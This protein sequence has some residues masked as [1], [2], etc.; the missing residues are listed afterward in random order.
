LI[1]GQAPQGKM[2]FWGAPISALIYAP[3]GLF[4]PGVALIVFKLTG[5]IAC[6]IGL[7]LLFREYRPTAERNGAS[8][9]WFLV[10]FTGLVMLYQPFW[11]VY[12]VGGQTTP[13]VFLLLVLG[14][15][16][17]LRQRLV[18]VAFAMLLVVLMKPA[19]AFVPAILFLLSG[20]RFGVA[21]VTLFAITGLVSLALFGVELHREFLDILRRGSG[22]PS[23]WPF[24]SSLYII[25][26]AFR[27][28]A[29]Q[30]PVPRAGGWFP[31]ALR[32]ALKLTVLATFVRLLVRSRKEPWTILQRRLFY[33][34]GAIA[35]CLLISQVVWEHYLA[36]LF[37]P[38]V[39]LVAGFP[40][41][42]R[43]A[44]RHLAIIFGLS[45]LQNLVLVML[46]RDH[47]AVTSTPVLLAV[48]L[49]KAGPLLGLLLFIW[50]HEA[51][52]F[53]LVGTVPP[54]EAEP[55]R[56]G[57]ELAASAVA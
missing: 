21:L 12:R 45:V 47:V 26:D 40:R 29:N 30:V 5:T 55:V 51:A 53:R 37:I 44:K 11:T 36:V 38:L 25:A 6:A 13:F 50:F 10:A 20:R 24:N 3:L 42:E 16:A 14:L 7:V 19:F 31:D 48:S 56:Q 28:V 23:P 33:Y 46:F 35:F 8:A 32:V 18:A 17:Y 2:A 39:F 4:S 9:G 1:A 27:P 34:L 52:L 49:V 22:K 54:G 43:R 57:S 15:R 41:L